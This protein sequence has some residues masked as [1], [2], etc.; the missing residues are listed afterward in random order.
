[1]PKPN[2]DEMK[3]YLNDHVA[4]DDEPAAEMRVIFYLLVA[5]VLVIVALIAFAFMGGA[6]DAGALRGCAD[7]GAAECMAFAQE[8]GWK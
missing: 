6:S 2:F 4:R 1:M 3:D 5:V 8:G 7:L